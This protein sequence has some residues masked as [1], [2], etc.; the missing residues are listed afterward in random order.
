MFLVEK[1]KLLRRFVTSSTVVL[2]NLSIFCTGPVDIYGANV[3]YCLAPYVKLNSGVSYRIPAYINCLMYTS[4]L[5]R[6]TGYLYYHN[7]DPL[8]EIYFHYFI[9]VEHVLNYDVLNYIAPWRYIVF[10]AIMFLT[11]MFLTLPTG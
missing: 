10:I 2:L 1:Q 7:I 5:Q 6:E 9:S 11:S 4:V 3:A 8:R